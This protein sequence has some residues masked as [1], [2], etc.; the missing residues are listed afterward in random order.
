ME[1]YYASIDDR[2]KGLDVNKKIFNAKINRK[3]LILFIDEIWVEKKGIYVA[4]I[5]SES[6]DYY[7]TDSIYKVLDYF[8]N[9]PPN[10]TYFLFEEPTYEEAFEYCKDHC[11][12]HE[13]GLNH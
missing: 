7:V 11:E 8:R 9:S 12:I 10:K 4:M 6:C 1:L 5:G 13:L 2:E 3:Q